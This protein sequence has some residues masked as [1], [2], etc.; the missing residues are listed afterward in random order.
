MENGLGRRRNREWGEQEKWG[1][2]AKKECGAMNWGWELE[3][4]NRHQA[5]YAL[6]I[7]SFFSGYKQ[8]KIPD[9]PWGDFSGHLIVSGG[10]LRSGQGPLQK[11]IF[12]I[13]CWFWLWKSFN[14][15]WTLDGYFWWVFTNWISPTMQNPSQRTPHIQGLLPL[16]IYLCLHHGLLF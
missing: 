7:H 9:V 8:F 2:P 14:H 15:T 4:E 1:R 13:S 3:M 6:L 16:Q 10:F 11:G 5:D 12:S